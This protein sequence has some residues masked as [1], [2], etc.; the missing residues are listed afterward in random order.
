MALI[1]PP[2]ILDL[3]ELEYATYV[4]YGKVIDDVTEAAMPH[5][6]INWNAT[7]GLCFAYKNQRTVT[8]E[9][10]FFSIRLQTL[11]AAGTFEATITGYE[12]VNEAGGP[13]TTAKPMSTYS[14]S[15]LSA[16]I[17][18]RVNKI[19]EPM[20]MTAEG[21]SHGTYESAEWTKDSPITFTPVFPSTTDPTPSGALYLYGVEDWT[22][23]Q[24]EAS[25]IPWT[26]GGVAID[27]TTDAITDRYFSIVNLTHGDYKTVSEV[28]KYHV[29]YDTTAPPQSGIA[30]ASGL[31]P[32]AIYVKASGVTDGLSGSRVEHQFVN[33]TSEFTS[34]YASGL[35]FIEQG[36]TENTA[37]RVGV[38]TKDAAGNESAVKL[39]DPVE[40]VST[41]VSPPQPT[42]IGIGWFTNTSAIGSVNLTARSIPN[43]TTGN[44]GIRYKVFPGADADPGGT[45]IEDS[46]WMQN[47]SYQ[48]SN[49]DPS[50]T[51][52]WGVTYRNQDAVET[53][54]LLL[55]GSL[56]AQDITQLQLPNFTHLP[57]INIPA[58]Q[59][60]AVRW[61]MRLEKIDIIQTHYRV[62]G[63]YISKPYVLREP[64][65]QVRLG[66]DVVIPDGYPDGDWVEFYISP[67]NGLTKYP[68]DPIDMGENTILTF[69]SAM[70]ESEKNIASLLGWT[71]VDLPEAPTELSVVVEVTR[72]TNLVFTTPL[73]YSYDLRVAGIS[74][75][76]KNPLERG[77]APQA[78]R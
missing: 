65:Y 75:L 13:V 26:S 78:R 47:N 20:T 21:S 6:T 18:L 34:T 28:L 68:I 2:R 66:A 41:M 24:I 3:E 9:N 33:A 16:S 48:F 70:T 76:H 25:G 32:T 49:I 23:A 8:D 5:M 40:A 55:N 11:N 29:I 27:L 37:Y 45:V 12:V 43:I 63:V 69:N 38:R 31:S 57:S 15:L 60:P 14:G 77:I 59:S 10:G 7:A 44:S 56:D 35:T 61:G 52:T 17:T 53:G 51:Y 22:A 50:S 54:Q 36:L 1:T 42:D 67:D 64:A 39:S 19:P 72:P 58:E 71:F 4:E 74:K 46:G 73:V 62:G 30:E